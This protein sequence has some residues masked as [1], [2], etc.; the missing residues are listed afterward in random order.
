MFLLSLFVFL[1]KGFDVIHTNNPPDILVF[2]AAFYKILGKRLV[3]DHRDLA[4]EM[5]QAVFGNDNRLAYKILVWLEQLSCRLADHIIAT[6]Q[7]YK[8]IEM[9]RGGVLAEHIS[10]VRSGPDLS[11]IHP[12]TPDPTLKKEGKLLLCFAGGIGLHDGVDYL[13]RALRHLVCDLGRTDFF[14]VL[15]GGGKASTRMKLLSEELGLTNFVQF[16]GWVEDDLFL[17]Y[18]S[19]ADICLAPDP[20]NAFNDRSTMIKVNEYAAMGKPIVAFDLPEHRVTAQEAAIYALPNDELEFAKKIAWL[21]ENPKQ[22]EKMGQ[23]GRKRAETELSWSH[24]VKHLLGAYE[25]LNCLRDSQVG[26]EARY[27]DRQYEKK[28]YK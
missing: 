13:L 9:E 26:D 16:T 4:P 8:Q 23:I 20:S 25:S 15:V 24:Q 17:R 19:T 5:Y 12:V 10:I 21:M 22:R 14:C 18:L 28:G 27:R 2:I 3:F 1:R 6:N 7:S 11:I